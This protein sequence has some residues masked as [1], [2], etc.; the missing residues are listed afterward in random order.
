MQ[1]YHASSPF[2]H[3]AEALK[4]RRAVRACYLCDQGLPIYGFASPIDNFRI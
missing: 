3:S 1:K 2:A 4:E